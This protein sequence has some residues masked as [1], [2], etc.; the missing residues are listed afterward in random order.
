MKF[1]FAT[2]KKTVPGALM[3]CEAFT[4]TIAFP[5]MVPLPLE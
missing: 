5:P 1:P 4:L 2:V 3:F